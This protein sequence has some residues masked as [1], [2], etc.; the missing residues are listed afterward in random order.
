MN[1][2]KRKVALI[3]GAGKGSGSLL[4]SAFAERGAIVAANDIS[5]VNVQ[6]VVDQ[7]V[8]NGGY[9]KAYID[10]VAKKVAA[11]SLVKQ[12]EDDFGCIDVLINHAAVQPHVSLLDMDE[13]DWHRVLDVNLTGAFLMIQSVGRVMR[14]KGSGV[15]IN[16]ITTKQ[17]EPALSRRAEWRSRI[18][19]KVEGAEGEAAFVA[20]MAALDGLTRLAAHELRPYGIQVY[21][22][23]NS[24]D[25]VVEN[26][27]SLLDR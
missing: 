20:S 12:V 5:P 16:L 19:A 25:R 18:E 1:K 14:E 4:A 13:W 2:L 8:A 11:Q 9:A 23:E 22:V 17:G 21:A 3:T 26:V 10:D 7:I 15:I 6:D 24:A 27:F